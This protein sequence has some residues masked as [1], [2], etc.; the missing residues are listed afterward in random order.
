MIIDPANDVTPHELVNRGHLSEIADVLTTM[1]EA[2][3]TS[4]TIR[5]LVIELA[6][7]YGMH[8]ADTRRR[9]D[10]RFDLGAQT[11][12]WF[13]F[14][15]VSDHPSKRQRPSVQDDHRMTAR[16]QGIISRIDPHS[17]IID[18][19]DGQW[20]FAYRNNLDSFTV[21]FV[22]LRVGMRCSFLTA[23]SG[24]PQDDQRAIEIR[25]INT[26]PLL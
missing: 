25:V 20:Y 16:P 22:D 23:W 5:R 17:F 9:T 11:A 2:N 15:R 1:L 7:V 26:T 14:D 19:D 21:S 24:R 18:G 6:M 10:A 3:P 4:T 13:G 12:G 8:A